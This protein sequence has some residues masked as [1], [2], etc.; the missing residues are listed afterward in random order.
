[1]EYTADGDRA[2]NT[3]PVDG[4]P[5]VSGLQL[6]DVRMSV[7]ERDLNTQDARKEGVQ[8]CTRRRS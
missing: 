6:R 4:M 2:L 3:V 8:H 1:M 5:H 7:D